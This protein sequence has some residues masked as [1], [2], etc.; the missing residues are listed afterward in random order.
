MHL[1]RHFK[2]SYIQILTTIHGVKSF[3]F[4]FLMLPPLHTPAAVSVQM[5]AALV[6]HPNNR[7]P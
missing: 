5:P 7:K 4:V 2:K 6:R 3:T 1:L